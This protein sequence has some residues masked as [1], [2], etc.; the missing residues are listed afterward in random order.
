MYQS[1]HLLKMRRLWPYLPAVIRLAGEF[2]KVKVARDKEQAA[3]SDPGFADPLS[4]FPKQDAL[5][6][7]RV[8]L[9]PEAFVDRHIEL[10]VIGSVGAGLDFKVCCDPAHE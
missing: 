2:H 3:L 5:V 8:F 7:I 9:F 4:S 1:G 10:D 6:E